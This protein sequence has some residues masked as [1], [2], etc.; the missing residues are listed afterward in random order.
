MS[1]IIGLI[2]FIGVIVVLTMLICA[3]ILDL[4]EDDKMEKDLKNK[5][6]KHGNRK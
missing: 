1:I 3:A 4:I 5:R 6:S 2:M